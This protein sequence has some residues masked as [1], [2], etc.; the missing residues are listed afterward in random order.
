MVLKRIKTILKDNSGESIAEVL[1]AFIV[2]TI[3]MVL[4]ARGLGYATNSQTNAKESRVSADSSMK[5]L[6]KQLTSATPTSDGNGFTIY[7]KDPMSNAVEGGT[8]SVTPYTYTDSTS[9][10]T[11]VVFM[12]EE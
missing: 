3:M 5:S 12:P 2:L 4:F 11:Y 10:N 7:R 9:G 6:Q 8:Y 1:V